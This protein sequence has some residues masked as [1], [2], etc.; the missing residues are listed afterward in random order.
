MNVLV[1][2]GTGFVG[3]HLVR[4]LSAQGHAVSTISRSGVDILDQAGVR[5]LVAQT[6]PDRIYHL[7]AQSLPRVSWEQPGRTFEVNVGGTINLFEA[8]RAA[9]IQ[10]TVAVFCSSSEYAPSEKPIP[11]DAPMGPL[12][13]YAISKLAQDHLSRQYGER[14]K[15]RVIRIRP[16]FITGPGKTGDVCSDLARRI[17]AIERAG[18]KADPPPVAVGNVEIVRD[19][20]DVRDAL[21][22]FT[23]LAERGE[24]GQAY[25]VA[26]GMGLSIGAIVERLRT[27]SGIP[28]ETRVDPALVR[29]IDEKVKV[30]DASRLRALGWAPSHD[31]DSMLREILEYW[32]GQKDV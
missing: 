27:I 15:L 25:N 28:F 32:R 24:P 26:T 8:I 4:H 18:Q 19:F 23:L 20:M 9:G 6:R 2:G 22:A 11:E 3:A 31:V 5:N 13:P 17:V 29:P 16:F 7:A 1:T 14:Y 30:G 10:P 12:S 21:A